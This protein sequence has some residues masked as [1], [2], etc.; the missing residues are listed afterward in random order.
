VKYKKSYK[1]NKKKST[2]F[3][4]LAYFSHRFFLFEI[5]MKKR[6]WKIC[7]GELFIFFHSFMFF[8]IK[9]ILLKG[10][11]VNIFFYALDS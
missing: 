9:K 2:G 10:N 3:A 6:I 4:V 11:L 1:I 5:E 8:R 7:R